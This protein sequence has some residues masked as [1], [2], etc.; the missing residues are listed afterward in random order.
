[1]H[2]VPSNHELLGIHAGSAS[3]QRCSTTRTEIGSRKLLG[4]RLAQ[5]VPAPQ[6]YAALAET[7]AGVLKHSVARAGLW[8]R[9]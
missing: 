8:R 3:N 2:S 9:R 7:K 1:M 4:R 5:L 6:L